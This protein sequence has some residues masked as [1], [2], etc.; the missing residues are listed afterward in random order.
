MINPFAN[1][2]II[3]SIDME[4]H[5]RKVADIQNRVRYFY[6]KKRKIKIYHGGTNSTR[7]FERGTYQYVNVEDL[8]NVIE[9]NKD[10]KY[11]IVEPDVPLD[12]LIDATLKRGLIPPMVAEFPGITVGGAIQGGSGESSSFRWGGFHDTCLEYEV[13]T[14]DGSKKTVSRTKNSDLFW[15]LACAY[16][17]LGVITLVKIKLVPSTKYVK[18]SYHPVVSYKAA[19][20]KILELTKSKADFIDGI[21]FGR[22]RGV[23]LEGQYTNEKGSLKLVSFHRAVDEWYYL[24][25]KKMLKK[26]GNYEEVILLRDYIFRY[27]K[28]GFWTAQYG[29]QSI[30]FN[31]LSRF[32]LSSFLNTRTLYKV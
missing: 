31:R 30:P 1:V 7:P 32:M 12:K 24:H 9:V 28:G 22:N 20:N 23:I 14:G 29:F 26:P 6:G 8:N 19:N 5:D 10:K 18:L 2:I 17:T 11:A 15:G 3:L 13:V 4:A 21:L 27:D 25:V 16:G